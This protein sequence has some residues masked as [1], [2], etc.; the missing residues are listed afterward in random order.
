MITFIFA[1]NQ[2]DFAYNIFSIDVK[3]GVGCDYNL[4][5]SRAQ[6]KMDS[7]GVASALFDETLGTRLKCLLSASFGPLEG[8]KVWV[9][10]QR[11]EF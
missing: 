3:A 9:K 8:F 11:D 4:R 6:V 7:N 1:C 10:N 5:Q 2:V